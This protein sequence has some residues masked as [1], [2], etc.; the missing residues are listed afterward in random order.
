MED[1]VTD[2]AREGGHCIELSGDLDRQTA[3]IVHLE[4]RRLGK[5]Y[6]LTVKGLVVERMKEMS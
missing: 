1:Q 4:I 5:R 3:E 2:D 6:G